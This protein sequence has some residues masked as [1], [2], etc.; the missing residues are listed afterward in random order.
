MVQPHIEYCYVCRQYVRLDQTREECAKEQNCD[1]KQCPLEKYF[2]Y[3][4]PEKPE[5]NAGGKGTT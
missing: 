4:H 2:H 5:K 1:S 3:A